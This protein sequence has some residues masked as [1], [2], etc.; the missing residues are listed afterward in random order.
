MDL[1]KFT[2]SSATNLSSGVPIL[3]YDSIMWIERYKSPGEFTLKAKLSSGLQNLLPLGSIISHARTYDACIVENHEIV[4]SADLDPVITITGR[5]LDSYLE[6]RIVGL[7]IAMTTPTVP[8]TQYTLAVDK[9][10]NQ[11]MQLI[12]DHIDL[13][14]EIYAHS[15]NISSIEVE[16]VIKRQTV[17]QAVQDL[18]SLD[19]LGIRVVRKNPYGAITSYS[20]AHT[21]LYVHKGNDH[22]NDVIFSWNLGE[23]EGANYLFS[24]KSLKNAALVQSNY[25]EVVVY[26][27]NTLNP[28]DIRFMLVDASDLDSAYTELPTTA[29]LL[30]LVEQLATRG[31]E[32]LSTQN[33]VNISSVDISKATNYKYREDYDIGDIVSIS[34]NYGVIEKRR[35]VEFVEI[36]DENGEVGYPTLSGI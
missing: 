9:L 13:N 20:S 1:F 8:F 33:A 16:R 7:N 34:G 26:D 23:L 36:E 35:V 12:N 5:S 15:E 29:Q 24:L 6:N 22:S 14:D 28:Y 18:L 25:L 11:I 3:N 31:F 4:E 2:D 30:V 27:D 32:S 19:D 21:S 17:L 10:D